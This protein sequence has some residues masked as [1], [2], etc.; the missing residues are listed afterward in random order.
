MGEIVCFVFRN[1]FMSKKSASVNDL[2]GVSREH[3][4][5][6]QLVNS[7]V[8][9]VFTKLPDSLPPEGTVVSDHSSIHSLRDFLNY[10][11]ILPEKA[12]N[13]SASGLQHYSQSRWPHGSRPFHDFA[14]YNS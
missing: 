5:C 14:W 4:I 2:I 12:G 10:T 6:W 13:G 7:V 9:A 1:Y 8:T 3:S 11:G